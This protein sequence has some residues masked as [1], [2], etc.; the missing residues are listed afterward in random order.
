M[1]RYSWLILAALGLACGGKVTEVSVG[2]WAG[3]TSGSGGNAG[4]AS[5][6]G[7]VSESGAAGGSEV[8]LIPI[9][10]G[11]AATLASSACS[12]YSVESEPY[13]SMGYWLVDSSRSMSTLLS[14][15]KRSRFTSAIE[16]V[17]QGYNGVEQAPGCD[18][19]HATV[20][21][22]PG[23]ATD[24]V[25]EA[26]ARDVSACFDSD[27][28]LS[29]GPNPS[30]DN[31]DLEAYL[32]GS[33]LEGGTPTLDAYRYAV[34]ALTS[35]TMLS[36][37][38]VVLATDGLPSIEGGCVNNETPSGNDSAAAS[39]SPLISEIEAA[40]RL[41]VRT[42]VIGTEGSEP[43]RSSLS[44]AA[45]AGG[46]AQVG[47]DSKGLA[48]YCHLDLTASVGIQDY[49]VKQFADET[50]LLFSCVYSIPNTA[51]DGLAKVDPRRSTPIITTPTSSWL[52]PLD[53]GPA[54]DCSEGFRLLSDSQLELCPKTCDLLR[55]DCHAQIYI[56]YFCNQAPA[57][58]AQ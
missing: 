42:Y 54:A 9:T 49:F 23:M 26:A 51:A 33:V 35:D 55:S 19:R 40:A 34:S 1:A 41:G 25:V 4:R 45:V 37:R 10:D 6:G 12:G 32:A 39:W 53:E 8:R 38:Y 57:G 47:C 50:P 7:S 48:P 44:L 58:P 22:F 31:A 43:A 46:R 24:D 14:D 28:A 11:E 27:N 5:A 17:V 15:G 52:V 56:L 21:R 3:G 18:V 2:D 30:S 13:I 36:R 16:A 29:L 20:L